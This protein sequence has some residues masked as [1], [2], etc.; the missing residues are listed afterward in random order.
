MPFLPFPTLVKKNF[1]R[2][3][4]QS[5][6]E[7]RLSPARWR[8]DEVALDALLPEAGPGL[9]LVLASE[10]LEGRLSYVDASEKGSE[11]S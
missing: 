3:H 5:V 7:K 8:H 9:D 2:T 11:K 6:E 4:V 1:G 10:V